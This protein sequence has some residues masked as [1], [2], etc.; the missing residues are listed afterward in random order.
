MNRVGSMVLSSQELLGCGNVAGVVHIHDFVDAVSLKMQAGINERAL[1]VAH[2]A[3]TLLNATVQH[4][5]GIIGH[6]IYAS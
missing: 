5:K 4:L 3:D 6:G 2:A 1:E